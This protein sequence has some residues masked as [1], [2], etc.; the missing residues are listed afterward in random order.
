MQDLT[1]LHGRTALVCLKP[2][3]HGIEEGEKLALRTFVEESTQKGGTLVTSRKVM[4]VE[5][6]T[7]AG[8]RHQFHADP[9]DATRSRE[10]R[11]Q[12][13]PNPFR[14]GTTRIPV[15]HHTIDAF[16]EF[17]HVPTMPGAPAPANDGT[18]LM[19]LVEA[20][21]EASTRQETTP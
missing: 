3:F 11:R 5:L 1:Y 7:A 15:L 2:G 14:P 16:V 9:H 18:A 17:F 21:I 13:A 8:A 12:P 10:A 20:I 4:V 19:D 6:T